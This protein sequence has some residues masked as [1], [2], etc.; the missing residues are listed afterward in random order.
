MILTIIGLI[1]IILSLS[2]NNIGIFLNSLLIAGI[3][4]ILI[5]ISVKIWKQ[6]MISQWDVY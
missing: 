6:K 5:F 4:I 2:Y 3:I 1:L